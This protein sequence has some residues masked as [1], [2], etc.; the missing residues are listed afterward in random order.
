MEVIINEIKRGCIIRLRGSS[1][2]VGRSG[3]VGCRV[4]HFTVKKR[5]G[6]SSKRYAYLF[7]L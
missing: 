5:L 1:R 6:G 3:W 2:R 7:F 4:S